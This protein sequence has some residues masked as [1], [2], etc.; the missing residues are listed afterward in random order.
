MSDAQFAP[1]TPERIARNESIFREAN[2]KIRDRAE[3][4]VQS[5]ATRVPFICECAAPMC[6]E[7]LSLTLAEYSEIRANDRWFLNAVGHN[8]VVGS[9]ATVVAANER[10][11]IAEKMGEAGEHA[12]RFAGGVVPEVRDG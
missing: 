12:E 3:A 10:Y 1:T 4:S 6:R 8:A 9:A 11:E 5:E 2:E 7:L